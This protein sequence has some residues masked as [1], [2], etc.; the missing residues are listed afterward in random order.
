M[1]SGRPLIDTYSASAVTK[2]QSLNPTQVSYGTWYQSLCF[3]HKG[4][5]SPPTPTPKTNLQII[6]IVYILEALP[7]G[8]IALPSPSAPRDAR[9][10]VKK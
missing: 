3:S 7:S 5:S 9:H 4:K 10:N 8:K 6:I 1:L 2:F